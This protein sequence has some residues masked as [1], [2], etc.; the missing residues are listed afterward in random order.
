LLLFGSEA[1]YAVALL[2]G[3]VS[4]E[5]G[6]EMSR[7]MQGVKHSRDAEALRAA[8]KREGC[9]V[10]TVVRSEM[11]RAMDTWNYEGFSEVEARHALIRSRGFCPLHTWQ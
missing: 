7:K 5:E 9:L 2:A 6:D 3:A 4:R 10:C 8:C 11:E 1:P